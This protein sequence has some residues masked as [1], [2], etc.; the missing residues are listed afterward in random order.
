MNI[1][2]TR[3]NFII[4]H[5]GGGIASR[6]LGMILGENGQNAFNGFITFGTPHLGTPAADRIQVPGEIEKI[7]AEICDNIVYPLTLQVWTF[8]HAIPLVNSYTSPKIMPIL[9][10]HLLVPIALKHIENHL[11]QGIEPQLT[12]NFVPNNV[13]PMI[14]QNNAAFYGIE[15]DTDTD[16]DEYDETMTARFSGAALGDPSTYQL[17]EAG[18]MDQAG[19]DLMHDAV[20]FFENN[21]VYWANAYNNIW[22]PICG[23]FEAYKIY[24]ANKKAVNWLKDV[25]IWWKDIIG[26]VG[27]KIERVGCE[28][29]E[30]D[31]GTLVNTSY[32]HDMDPCLDTGNPGH[33]SYT[34]C[35]DWYDVSVFSKPADG[36]ILAESAINAPGANYPPREMPGSSHFQMRN[37]RNTE[38]AIELIFDF[39]LNAAFFHTD[40]R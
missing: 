39:G 17:W 3:N 33:G 15:T 25:N 11:L 19:I 29:S 23:F 27:V 38:D 13:P 7:V 8:I 37:D 18:D 32:Y 14:T 10:D 20:S 28:C 16:N 30:Y 5:S 31:H 24:Q 1:P 6:E 4:A 26:A 36:F 40:R 12:T 21:Y 34:I 35:N 2:E 22:C 9:C